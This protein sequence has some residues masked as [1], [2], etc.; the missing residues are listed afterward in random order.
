MYYWK[1]LSQEE[2]LKRIENV[3]HKN[4]NFYENPSLGCPE[5]KLDNNVFYDGA[6]NSEVPPT[7]QVYVPHPNHINFHTSRTSEK[8]FSRKQE[9]E[10]TVQNVIVVNIFK[11]SPNSY[12]R[13]ISPEGTEANIEDFWIYRNHYMHNFSA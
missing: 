9:M 6:P 5:W 11:A 1:K 4:V 13:S 3:L 7:A 2:T 8:A 10:R 12:D